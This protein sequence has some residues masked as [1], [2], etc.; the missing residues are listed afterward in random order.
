[1]TEPEL[2]QVL[3][4]AEEL[5][6]VMKQVDEVDIRKMTKQTLKEVVEDIMEDHE[7][8]LEEMTKV[9]LKEI[10]MEAVAMNPAEKPKVL[11]HVDEEDVGKMTKETL[12]KVA[13]E[14]IENKLESIE[15][16][17][18]QE[19]KEIVMEVAVEKEE[20][21]IVP[22]AEEDIEQMNLKELKEFVKEASDLAVAEKPE[23]EVTEEDVAKVGLKFLRFLI[24]ICPDVHGGAEGVHKRGGGGGKPVDDGPDQRD[25]HP[26][27]VPGAAEGLRDGGRHRDEAP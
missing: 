21:I 19:L 22:V 3:M 16:M 25:R 5:P 27:D 9:E 2:K 4:E 11:Q 12:M 15:E 6:K 14:V 10:V 23:P 7:E 13:E 24:P 18:K 17:T 26:G 1:M 20:L 8:D